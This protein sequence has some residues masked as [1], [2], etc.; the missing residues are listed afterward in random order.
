MTLRSI[1]GYYDSKTVSH[2][3]YNC[4]VQM[5][6]EEVLSFRLSCHVEPNRRADGTIWRSQFE[7]FYGEWHL[8]GTETP[9]LTLA[10]E[11]ECVIYESAWEFIKAKAIR[12]YSK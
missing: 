2:L 1:P 10:V 4:F 11:R 5:V 9:A 12:D 3:E 8:I 6:Q 7:V